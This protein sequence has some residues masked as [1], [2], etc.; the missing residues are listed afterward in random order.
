MKREQSVGAWVYLVATTG[1]CE[2]SECWHDA[3]G[4]LVALDEEG[5]GRI[6][7]ALCEECLWSRLMAGQ[8]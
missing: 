8:G 2:E 5:A 3:D 7:P 4:V 1:D 6:S